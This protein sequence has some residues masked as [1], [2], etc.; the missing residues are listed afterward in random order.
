[1]S[2][3][4]RDNSG[5]HKKGKKGGLGSSYFMIGIVLPNVMV[6]CD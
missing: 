4:V 2:E 6:L 3:N 1:M 5:I